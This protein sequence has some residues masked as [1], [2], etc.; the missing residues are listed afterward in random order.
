LAAACSEAIIIAQEGFPVTCPGKMD[1]ST[2]N[3]LSIPY[4]L[5]LV[6]TTAV[7]LLTRPSSSPS[8]VVPAYCQ[9]GTMLYLTKLTY[10]MIGASRTSGG[11]KLGD[12]RD[13]NT[14]TLRKRCMQLTELTNCV[15][16]C[17]EPG[18]TQLRL[19]IPFREFCKFSIPLM[20]AALSLSS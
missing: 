4:T 15:A 18:E 13:T 10:P 2:T 19:L 9:L 5:V 1:A 20:M 6:S 7:P 11:R 3:R 8:L 12:V 17:P 14:C 16:L